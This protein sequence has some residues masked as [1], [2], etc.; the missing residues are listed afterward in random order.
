[1]TDTPTLTPTMSVLLERLIKYAKNQIEET[2][3]LDPFGIVT[4]IDK[5]TTLIAPY[6]AADADK[7]IPGNKMVRMVEDEIRRLREKKSLS[8]AAVFRGVML[9]PE[10]GGEETPA[11]AG[12]LEEKPGIA[13][14]AIVEFEIEDKHVILGKRLIIQKP[15]FLL[16]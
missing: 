5:K 1:M 7:G 3:R 9:R 2:G 13:V 11:M 6:L 4:G 15:P 16:P 8:S 12:R 14:Q 10:E